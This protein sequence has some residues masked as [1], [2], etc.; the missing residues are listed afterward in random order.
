MKIS[1]KT[2]LLGGV[3]ALVLGTLPA[4]AQQGPE[5]LLPPGFDSVSPAPAPA[6]APPPPPPP[7]ASPPPS[8]ATPPSSSGAAPR[9]P[10]SGSAASSGGGVSAPGGLD[11]SGIDLNN[12][13]V[14]TLEEDLFKP[15]YRLSPAERRTTEQIGAIT[16]KSGGL[17]E[18][19][20]GAMPGPYLASIIEN[21]RSPLVSRWGHILLR[22]TLLSK[23]DSPAGINPADWTAVRAWRLLRLG[24]ADAARMLVSEV[25]VGNY[26][27]L[28][29]EVAMQAHLASAD[30]AGLCPV[31]PAAT[32][33]F[34]TPA[35]TMFRPICFG[36]SGEQVL[37][38]NLLRR[39]RKEKTATGIDYR[40]AEKLTGAGF[41]GRSAVTIE[42]DGIKNMNNWRF[43]LALA[44]GVEPPDRLLEK[45]GPHVQG[46]L[47]RMPMLNSGDRV[48]ASDTAAAMGVMSNR[49]L[50][51]LYSIAYDDPE[52][53]EV[54]QLR[55]SNLRDAYQAD[56][57]QGRIAAMQQLWDRSKYARSRYS[58]LVLTA[59]AAARIPPQAGLE[60]TDRLIASMLTAGYDKNAARWLNFVDEGSRAWGQI[61]LAT[62][63]KISPLDAGTLDSFNDAD[64]SE[65]EYLS[66]LFLAGVAGLGRADSDAISEFAD[67]LDVDLNKQTRWTKAIERAAKAKQPGTVAILAGLALRDR[68]WKQ[69]EP[70]RLYHIIS[71]LREAG[72][73]AEARMIAAEAIGRG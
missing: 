61:I 71:A 46:W 39:A 12:F 7:S 31:V 69:M 65:G 23:V 40:L 8:S 62:P 41:G 48:R 43:G 36:L 17:P 27:P 32:E 29:Y 42:W 66:G 26:S 54:Y 64:E 56:T 49:A 47:V 34:E 35:W 25:D 67:Q 38:T 13:D 24:E 53:E 19:A 16:S 21:T 44:T 52:A 51:D 14:N 60:D 5:S 3:G 50:V 15:N 18:N 1:H 6:P 4:L 73:E 68:S 28:L 10:S 72:L 33:I 58:A 9:A 20:F 11:L 2:I 57:P 59:N 70:Y 45:S 37:A 22:R 63:G 30:P 55:A